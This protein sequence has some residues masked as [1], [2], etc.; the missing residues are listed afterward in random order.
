MLRNTLSAS[1]PRRI[2][3]P[4]MTGGSLGRL[5]TPPS[6][7]NAPPITAA[8]ANPS[9]LRFQRRERWPRS[10]A[11]TSSAST[12]CGA[13][14]STA[15]VSVR[16]SRVSFDGRSGRILRGLV[17]CP[18]VP[19]PSRVRR[20]ASLASASP[21]LRPPLQQVLK[22]AVCL[23]GRRRLRRLHFRQRLFD[24]VHCGENLFDHRGLHDKSRAAVGATT[25][26]RPLAS[27]SGS[28]FRKS[29]TYSRH[30]GDRSGEHDRFGFPTTA[31]ID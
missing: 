18:P 2:A 14:A 4:A 22:R 5:N 21:P 1:A 23:L 24:L 12:A 7:A 15:A 10:C 28:C 27:T 17:A 26:F 19:A 13:L 9:A 29:A 30:R 16:L 11:R 20:G 25:P 8:P 3:G 6:S 31:S